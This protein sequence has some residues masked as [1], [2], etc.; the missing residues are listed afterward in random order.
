MSTGRDP[1]LDVEA[2]FILTKRFGY[3][4]TKLL[5]RFPDGAPDSVIA[6]ALGIEEGE[7]EVRYQAIVKSLQKSVGV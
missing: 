6:T 2:D 7:V 3:S 5:E 4:L 1:R